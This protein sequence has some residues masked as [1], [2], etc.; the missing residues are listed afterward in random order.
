M[1]QLESVCL[2]M[3]DVLDRGIW[4]K[5]M[6][7]KLVVSVM[8]YNRNK[9]LNAILGYS[10]SI[11]IICEYREPFPKDREHS[12]LLESSESRE[13]RVLIGLYRMKNIDTFTL[14]EY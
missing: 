11:I 5:V 7:V 10:N 8:A 3:L 9:L 12:K 6:V 2:E 14:E 13:C 1:Y 4:Y